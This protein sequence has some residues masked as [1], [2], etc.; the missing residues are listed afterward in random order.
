VC[1]DCHQVTTEG[2]SWNVKEVKL[3]H[4]WMPKAR[5]DHK[6]HALA[7]CRDC[8][9]VAGSKKSSD[10]AMPA[11]ETCRKC[12]G[13]SRPAPGKVTSNCLL[14]HGFHEAGHAW[15]PQFRPRKPPA[16]FAQGAPDGR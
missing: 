7:P 4:G 9:D 10:V 11:I 15:D 6:R 8:H 1:V 16:R 3:G 14:C 13:G 2:K 5:F 12:H